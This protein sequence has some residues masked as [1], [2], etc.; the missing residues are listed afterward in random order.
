MPVGP[1][2][3]ERASGVVVVRSPPAGKL[4]WEHLGGFCRVAAV[5]E[6]QL[7]NIPRWTFTR[8]EATVEETNVQL[9]GSAC[10]SA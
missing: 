3:R 10:S 7:V 5:T 2:Y 6:Q 4:S 1:L 8:Y 9:C